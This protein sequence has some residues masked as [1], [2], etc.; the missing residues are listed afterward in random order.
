MECFLSVREVFAGGDFR[1]ASLYG[2]ST[3][4]AGT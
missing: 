3:Y 2:V 4:G 1:P